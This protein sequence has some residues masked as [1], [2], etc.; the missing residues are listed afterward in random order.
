MASNLTYAAPADSPFNGVN[1]SVD[2]AILDNT[3]PVLTIGVIVIV[4]VL[5]LAGVGYFFF[6]YKSPEDR[7]DAAAAQARADAREAAAAAAA[8]G[9]PPGGVAPA[10]GPPAR[11][12][13]PSAVLY[14]DAD[15]AALLP[16][17]VAT[18]LESVTDDDVRDAI[19][20]LARENGGASASLI[21]AAMKAGTPVPV[22]RGQN[23]D[24]LWDALLSALEKSP[25]LPDNIRQIVS[26]LRMEQCKQI[27]ARKGSTEDLLKCIQG[28]GP[29]PSATT[30]ATPPSSP[31]T[32]APSGAPAPGAPLGGS[33]SITTVGDTLVRSATNGM[34]Y[35][36]TWS[37]ERVEV[38]DDRKPKN[39]S[40]TPL[41]SN[42]G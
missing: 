4:G 24:E 11:G 26:F 20:D 31:I 34:K 15:V 17:A 16:A 37:T 22:V 38:C 7:A 5:V 6:K 25:N 29:Q 10:A 39:C 3:R 42:M 8:P 36:L 14:A 23:L 19:A 1:A 33:G 28:T 2:P 32:P 40:S 41:A 18:A 30:G 13:A 35:T 9:A 12:A 27:A 21:A